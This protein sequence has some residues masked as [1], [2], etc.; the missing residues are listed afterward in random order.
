MLE[1]C[2]HFI[3]LMAHL[4]GRGP[5]TFWQKDTTPRLTP[6]KST[7][8][9]ALG[10]EVPSSTTLLRLPLPHKCINALWPGWQQ[11]VLGNI[12]SLTGNGLPYVTCLH[13]EPRQ[14]G[15]AETCCSFCH[16]QICLLTL[17]S[18]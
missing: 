18:P 13:T 9:G 5:S 1:E 2:F 8:P 11:Q 15:C 16:V 4:L 17:N 14:R 12:W 3:S 10:P 6:Q 7:D